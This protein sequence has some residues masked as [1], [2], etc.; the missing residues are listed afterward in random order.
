M[1]CLHLDILF[2]ILGEHHGMQVGNL[3]FFVCQVERPLVYVF[4][5]DDVYLLYSL[6]ILSR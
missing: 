3:V 1:R 6:E 2:R 4:I 5:V